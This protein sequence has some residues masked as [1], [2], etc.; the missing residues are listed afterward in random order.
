MKR[1]R[2]QSGDKVKCGGLLSIGGKQHLEHARQGRYV[3]STSA[4]CPPW[5]PSACL[6]RPLIRND[7]S[8]HRF[9]SN[10]IILTVQQLLLRST[11]YAPRLQ[12]SM[13]RH[14]LA[15]SSSQTCWKPFVEAKANK[16][17]RGATT[18]HTATYIIV[19]PGS[20][21]VWSI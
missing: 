1:S 17:G 15:S 21:L 10:Y 20:G 6:T 4:L 14:Q 9:N 3:E 18:G 11:G 16:V 13:I 5:L 12:S 7:L 8:L 2:G 19:E